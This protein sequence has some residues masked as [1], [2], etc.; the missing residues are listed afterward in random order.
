MAKVAS[1][2]QTDVEDK[3]PG[4]ALS[5][6]KSSGRRRIKCTQSEN[7]SSN[8]KNISESSDSENGPGRD[9]VSASHS[10]PPKTKPVG[11]SGI[12]KR[13]SKRVAERVL[14]CMQKRQKKNAASDS[15]SIVSSAL[16]S[17]D[18]HLT[19][20]IANIIMNKIFYYTLSK[21]KNYTNVSYFLILNIERSRRNWFVIIC[22]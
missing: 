4:S 10:A 3:S 14:V 19:S 13:N 15:D 12:G 21:K 11:K 16:C 18:M 7:A 20:I 9:A 5:R 17:S 6:K 22:T 2:T 1:S 8:A